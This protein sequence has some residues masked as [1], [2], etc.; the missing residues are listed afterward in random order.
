MFLCNHLEYPICKLDFSLHNNALL[1]TFDEIRIGCGQK[2]LCDKCHYCER[3]YNL[4]PHLAENNQLIMR[5]PDPIT[6]IDENKYEKVLKEL[7]NDK[8][9]SE[10]MLF[11]R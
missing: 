9:N 7:K 1:P 8:F 5:E 4:A 3:F 10:D 11:E 2:C 6:T